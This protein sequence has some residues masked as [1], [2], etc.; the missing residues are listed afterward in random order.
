[1]LRDDVVAVV[2]SDHVILNGKGF[3]GVIET[4]RDA[5]KEF[6]KII[7]IEEH[8]TIGGLGSIIA[9]KILKNKIKAELC[10]YSLPDKFGPTAKYNY[11]LGYHGLDAKGITKKIIKLLK[12]K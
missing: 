5:A 11:L 1:M 6:K 3:R 2:P 8:T 7:T 4:A 9:E 10:S 12:D